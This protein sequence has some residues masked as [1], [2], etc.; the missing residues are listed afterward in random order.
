MEYDSASKNNLVDTLDTYLSCDGNLMKTSQ[1]LNIHYKTLTYR[2]NRAKELMEMDE[3]DG[4]IRLEIQLG[5]KIL[6][7][8]KS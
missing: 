5:I 2:V 1:Q 3:I 8:L 6:R 7:M 4:D